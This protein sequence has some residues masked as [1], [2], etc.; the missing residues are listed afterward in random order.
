[1][2]AIVCTSDRPCRLAE[3]CKNLLL[4]LLYTVSARS[5][6]AIAHSGHFLQMQHA[7]ETV[8]SRPV[9]AADVRTCLRATL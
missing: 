6:L 8:S 5:Q 1:M 4:L 9:L 2:I 3:A 7:L